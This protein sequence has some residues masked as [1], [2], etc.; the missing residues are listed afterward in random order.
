[1]DMDL[2]PRQGEPTRTNMDYCLV[3]VPRL[4]WADPGSQ[5]QDKGGSRKHALQDPHV[6]VFFWAPSILHLN[7]TST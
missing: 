4:L 2:E 6:Y 5:A 7:Y 3:G 1:M